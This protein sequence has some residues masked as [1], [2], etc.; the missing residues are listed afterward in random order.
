MRSTLVITALSMIFA[1]ALNACSGSS[2]TSSSDVTSRSLAYPAFAD[3]NGNRIND[4]VESPWHEGNGHAYAD[5]N[6]D[7]ICDYS[8]DGSPTWHGPGF[9]DED[10]NGICDY[11]QTGSARHNRHE[12]L[13]YHDHDH[14]QV[15]DY[16][17][18]MGH[19]DDNHPFTDANN[20]GICDLAQDG[21]PAWHGPGYIAADGNGIY[22]GR[23]GGNMEPRHGRNSIS[24]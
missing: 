15:N 22:D 24:S 12:G 2:P 1:L 6:G 14:N 7:G 23:E 11:W 4:Y 13:H 17:E 8:Q 5:G 16:H 19:L 3:G 18:R 20:D 9:M 21:G 10:G